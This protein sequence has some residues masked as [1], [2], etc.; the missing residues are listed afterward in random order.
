[1]SDI[2]IGRFRGGFCVYWPDP[3]TGKRRRHQL[4][5]RTR[6]E[7]AAEGLAVYRRET[8]DGSGVNIEKIWTAYVLDLGEKPTAKTMRY[9]GK[10][11]LPFFGTLTPEQITIEHCRAYA[12]MREGAGISQ[13]STHT[14]LGH[15]RSALTW[16]QKKARII[17]E[18]PYI[19]RPE[20]PAPKERYLTHQEIDRLLSA[21]TTP[22]T[23]LAIVLLLGTAARVGALLELTWGRVDLERG[24]INL[25]L[26]DSKT[27]K[28]RAVVPMNGMTRAALQSAE[29]AALSE[30]VIEYAGRPVKSIR[31]GFK[32]AVEAAGL[33]DVT[34]HT[35][36]HTAAVH[37]V[38]AGIPMEKVAQYLG[39]SNVAVTY[40]TYAR[41]A[42]S[43]MD[44]AAEV[45]NFTAIKGAS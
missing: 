9:T 6:E 12:A 18:A 32:A 15:L 31:N 37:M 30:Y 27:R 22:H 1:M 38:A 25:R 11:V 19:W 10:A 8:L 14:E 21:T 26:E 4:A 13:G 20:K 41:Y 5:A 45:L 28:G 34:L 40:S 17:A 16:A 3:V 44:D 24:I 29:E 23:R 42:P 7:A 33:E 43:H 2:A 35:L 39:H 36:R